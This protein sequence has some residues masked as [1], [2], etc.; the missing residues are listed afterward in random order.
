[1]PFAFIPTALGVCFLLVWAFIG[2]ILLRDG[3]FATQQ[4]RDTEIGILPLT[5]PR[6]AHPARRLGLLPNQSAPNSV[7][8]AAS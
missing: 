6:T 5:A 1:M 3:Q 4:D 8:R 7:V 2:G